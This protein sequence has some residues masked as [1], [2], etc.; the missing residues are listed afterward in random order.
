MLP[1]KNGEVI[2]FHG[3]KDS[4]VPIEIST[5]YKEKA[6]ENCQYFT[7]NGA[8]HFDL[9]DPKSPYFKEVGNK[10]LTSFL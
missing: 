2:L 7:I 10:I 5:N 3:N 4:E 1:I 9:V 8:G 6:Q